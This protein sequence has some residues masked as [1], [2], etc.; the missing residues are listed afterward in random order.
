MADLIMIKRRLKEALSQSGL[1]QVE[2]AKKLN[3]SQSCIAHYIKGDILP[4]LD[5]FTDICAL[6]DLDASYILGLS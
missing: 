3:I 2:L 5:K 1:S 6:L 4:S